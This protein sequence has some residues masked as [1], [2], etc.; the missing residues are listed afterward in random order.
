MKKSPLSALCRTGIFGSLDAGT[1]TREVEAARHQLKRYGRNAVIHF[2]GDPY[3]SLLVLVRGEV[4]A[5]MQPLADPVGVTIRVE[6]E[7]GLP[8][9]PADRGA[10]AI[11]HLA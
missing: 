7:E 9:V 10:H 8:A 3:T 11:G 5:L 4:D 6:P 2:Q 1:L